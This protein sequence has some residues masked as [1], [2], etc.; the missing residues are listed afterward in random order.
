MSTDSAA[1]DND[2]VAISAP[3]TAAPDLTTE[4]AA[5]DQTTD[6]AAPDLTTADSEVG[7]AHEARTPHRIT[8]WWQNHRRRYGYVGMAV[9]LVF[10][11][12]SMTPSLLPRS[13]LFQGVVS[14]AS[15][16]LGYCLGVFASWL[17]RFMM[18]RDEPWRPARARWWTYLGA[19]ALLGTAIMLIWWSRWQDQLRDLMG[20]DRLSW[21]AYPLVAII[22][23]L[24]FMLLMTIGQAWAG[25]VRWLVGKLETVAPPRVSAVAAALV[26][27]LFTA[28]VL[29]GVV[30]KY[31][32]KAL[33]STFAAI[34][35]ETTADS[36]PPTSPLR[37]G[38]PGSL[39]SWDSLGRQ[40]RIFVSNGP[41]QQQLSDFNGRPAQFPVRTFV[42]LGS[43][44]D[45]RA[46]A[47][48]A[49]EELERAGGL[50]RALV[51]VASTTGTG[52]INR[53]TVDSLEYMY[54]GNTATV[55]MQYSYLPSWLSFLVDAE[56]ARQAG[57][58]LF[59]AVSERVRA[60]PEAQRPKLVVFGESLG[61]FAGESAFGS[62][63][64]LSART[65]GA[66]FVGPTFNNTIWKDATRQRDPGSPEWLPV[67][68]GGSQ[69]R[70]IADGADLDRPDGPW[71]P[72]RVVY[73][74]HASDPISWWSPSLALSKPDWLREQRG[75]DV[76]GSMR[77]I[78]F[79]TFLQVSADM[80]VS[81]GVPDGHGHT[82]LAAIPKAWAA[83]L[84]P[85][86]WT[87][88][89]TAALIPLLRRS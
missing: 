64:S 42:G 19:L 30:A 14:G 52:W 59:E 54:N 73:L 74:Q 67:Y 36:S 43:G 56:R 32:M 77:W 1:T 29:N 7:T 11:W 10:L 18:S 89:K 33:N 53:A 9:A 5:P 75:R 76:L 57:L 68:D 72:G 48:L 23:V 31:S 61:S 50:D 62:V 51:A 84:Q 13:A 80:A 34:D 24:V 8:T 41:S 88:E 12:L 38:G 39:V 49:A 78:P 45:L 46:N 20:V 83:I 3:D 71:R 47:Q 58:A 37:S 25:L 82:F 28:F 55:S 81:N 6:T 70:F 35:G 60:R 85:P 4:T 22:A 26:V 2:P 27:V 44:D 63:Q 79:V 17:V 86:G 87:P 66:L 15:A 40:G 21:G 65:D 16:A 69:V